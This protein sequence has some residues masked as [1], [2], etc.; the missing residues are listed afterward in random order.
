MLTETKQ[1][2]EALRDTF[3]DGALFQRGSTLCLLGTPNVGKS[4]L[5][6]ALLDEE[7]AIVT[8]IAGTT[9]DVL[10]EELLID[11][12]PFRLFDTAGVRETEEI[13]EKEGIAR[14]QKTAKSSDLVLILLDCTRALTKD[15]ESLLKTYP[16]ALL[17]WNKVDLP[18]SALPLPG[19]EISAKCKTGLTLLKKAIVERIWES[20][21]PDKEQITITKE[22]HFSALNDAIVSITTVISGFEN[23]TSPEFLAF[24]LRQ[25]LKS[26]AQIIGTN[27]TEDILGAIFAKFCVGK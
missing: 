16:T 27:V 23:G 3:H 10:H 4:S 6:N 24:D 25:A 17:I 2:L 8:D 21:I 22:R 7:R 12:M 14:S 5:M 15:E 9:R 1:K 26:L 19:I 11:G 13:I 18:H 20:K